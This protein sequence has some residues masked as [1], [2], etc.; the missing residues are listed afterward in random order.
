MYLQNEEII[1]MAQC[2]QE[3]SLKMLTLPGTRCG[4]GHTAKKKMREIVVKK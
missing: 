4:Q 2:L 1:E 3:S